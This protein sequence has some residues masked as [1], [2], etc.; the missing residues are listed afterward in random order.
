MVKY[1]GCDASRISLD[2]KMEIEGIFLVTL[3]LQN[4]KLYYQ[5]KTVTSSAKNVV[6]ENVNKNK[7][8]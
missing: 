6:T 8:K 1:P 4:T 3:R 5:H 7:E 2:S